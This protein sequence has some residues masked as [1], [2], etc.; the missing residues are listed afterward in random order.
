ML[1]IDDTLRD[2]VACVTAHLHTERLDEQPADPA[3]PL[4][5]ALI[6]H[7]PEQSVP[8]LLGLISGLVGDLATATGTTQEVVWQDYALRLATNTSK[9]NDR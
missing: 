6:N 2:A 4:L 9:E 3:G 7:D 5:D 8:V 1:T